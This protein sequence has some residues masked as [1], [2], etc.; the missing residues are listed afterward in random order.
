MISV[1]AI[2]GE[3][4]VT[5]DPEIIVLDDLAPGD[6]VVH[7]V[8]VSNMSNQAVTISYESES[9]GP[10]T[11]G[12]HPIEVSYV[13][14]LTRVASCGDAPAL[15]AGESATLE[16]TASMPRNAGNEYQ[17]LDGE[18]VL[19]FTYTECGVPPEGAPQDG[20]LAATGVQVAASVMLA[21]V[22]LALGSLLLVRRR[23]GR[24]S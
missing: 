8:I 10:L 12:L 7:P 2:D 20:G 21:V 14:D 4:Q 16:V 9:T 23:R 24:A 17:N 1:S 19:T 3:D 5:A 22:L 11:E 6:R 13:W 15:P 18:A